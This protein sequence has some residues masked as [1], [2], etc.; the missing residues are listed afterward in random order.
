MPPLVLASTRLLPGNVRTDVGYATRLMREML[1]MGIQPNWVGSY[2]P[3]YAL[4]TRCSAKSQAGTVLLPI[5]L[6]GRYEMPGTDLVHA[7]TRR[8]RPCD[9]AHAGGTVLSAYAR[10][11][12]CPVLT[13]RLLPSAYAHAMRCTVLMQRVVLS[14]LSAYARA[15]RC[16]VLTSRRWKRG[17][18][19]RPTCEPTMQVKTP[20]LAYARATRC[21]VLTSR[22]ANPL[23]ACYHS[24]TRM[25]AARRC[26][27]LRSAIGLRACYAMSG[28]ETAYGA[29]G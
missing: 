29:I 21:P 18:E 9:I 19:Q 20:L 3:S 17:S 1:E 27:V 8:H 28:T 7:A 5:G 2:L 25:P 10:T 6:R 23:S 4:P 24:A 11:M 16:P 13:S 26:Q 12:Q 22:V 15:M 14:H